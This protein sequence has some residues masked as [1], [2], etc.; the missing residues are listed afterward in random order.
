MYMSTVIHAVMHTATHYSSDLYI[1]TYVYISVYIHICTYRIPTASS[2][3]CMSVSCDIYTYIG[4]I[5]LGVYDGQIYT[6]IYIYHIRM[7]MYVFVC[8]CMHIYT[9]VYDYRIPTA[10]SSIIQ[11]Q[12]GEDS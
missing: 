2:S 4:S 12:G 10:S 7:Y 9:C 6:C 1:Y 3:I 8:V 5:S 11:I